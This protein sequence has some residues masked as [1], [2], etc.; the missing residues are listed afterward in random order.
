MKI[1]KIIK[2]VIVVIIA[3]LTLVK[4]SG[5]TEKILKNEK[6]KIKMPTATSAGTLYSTGA[7]ITHMWNEKIPNIKASVQSSSGGIENINMV[8]DGECQVS[9]AIASNCY[10]AFHGQKLFKNHEFSKLRVI[11]GL[12]L[13]PNQFVVT[14]SSNI[15]EIKDLRNKKIAVSSAGSS[16][17]NEAKTHINEVNLK[18]PEDIQAQYIGFGESLAMLQNETIDGAWIM[19]GVPSSA[20]MQ[21]L[22]ANSHLVNFSDEFIRKLQNKYPWYIAYTIPSGTYPNQKNDIKTTAV[23]MVMFC[24]EDLSDEVVYELTKTFWENIDELA[25]TQKSLKNLNV[26]NAT[27]NIAD[28]PLHKGAEKYYKEINA[29]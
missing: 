3:V 10:E 19:A 18:F 28:L 15:Y 22:A 14:N 7:G 20:V 24:S 2:I 11:A 6:I 16:V 9:I 23:K 1:I 13:N 4:V 5:N 26:K 12:Y 25:K 29:L 17:Y 21:T 27:K 8:K